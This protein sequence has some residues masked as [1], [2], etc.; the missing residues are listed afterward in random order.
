M[1]VHGREVA[2]RVRAEAQ[3]TQSRAWHSGRAS[4]QV[5]AGGKVSGQTLRVERD[6][7]APL[8]ETTFFFGAY[9]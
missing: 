8:R 3:R 7:S 9:Q 5:I 6:P 4:G 1:A 2:K